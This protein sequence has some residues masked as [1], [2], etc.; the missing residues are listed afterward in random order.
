MLEIDY[1]KGVVA[2]L[3]ARN[4]SVQMHEDKLSNFIP[5]LSFGAN[6]VDGWIEVKWQDRAPKTLHDIKH[7]TAGQEDWL[8]KRQR[9]GNGHCYLL[10]G[11]PRIHLIWK[12]HHLPEVR[13]MAWAKARAFA[14]IE[15]ASVPDLVLS[16]DR[17]M[18]IRGG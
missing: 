12:A 7:F 17:F 9:A 3:I 18:R 1:K 10:V 2:A 11:T 6:F 8:I 16:M 14:A 15:A 13:K 5:D 4:W